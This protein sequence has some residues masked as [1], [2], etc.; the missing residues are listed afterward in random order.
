[1]RV[2]L[3][4]D[5]LR[6]RGGG[7]ER[8]LRDLG[9]FLRARGDEV[10][11]LTG[12]ASSAPRGAREFAF[13]RRVE[14]S[15]REGRF[16]SSLAVRHVLRAHV[17]E[18][19]GGSIE[20]GLSARAEISGSPPLARWL[21][22]SAPKFRVFRALEREA[23]AKSRRVLAVSALVARD[24][25]RLESGAA[26]REFPLGVDLDR[27]APTG[28]A[29]NLRGRSGLR[30]TDAALLFVG[31]DFDLKGLPAAIGAL[32]RILREGRGAFL[33]IAGSGSRGSWRRAR[34][35]ARE[36]GVA[37]R[38][39]FRGPVE[40]P[41]PLYRGARLLLHP[42]FYDPCSLATLEALACGLPVVTTARNGAA[43][44]GGE[45]LRA[46]E[47]PRDEEAIARA[48]LSLLE[49]DA[50]ARAAA[51]ASVEG[52][53]SRERFERLRELL[54]EAGGPLDEAASPDPTA[55]SVSSREAAGA[56]RSLSPTSL[57]TSRG[58]SRPGARSG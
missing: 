7:V 18:P 3:V 34:A 55:S 8:Y 28:Y 12:R 50:S 19:H 29:E 31:N 21:H 23:L 56:E 27:F 41:A 43:E 14:R 11:L 48:A 58:E 32:A 17:Y 36:V 2:A 30:A 26:I 6:R 20:A 9:D 54:V 15:L 35:R 22:R 1:M 44:V 38:V 13:A 10:F 25:R 52:R 5:R 40:D 39:V 4:V 47:D 24:L 57:P 37:D 42:T 33:A 49:P 51:R 45:G 16:E 46:V 53:D